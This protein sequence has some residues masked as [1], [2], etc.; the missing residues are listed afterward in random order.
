MFAE[1]CCS[2]SVTIFYR[3]RLFLFFFFKKNFDQCCEKE[4]SL[5]GF[6]MTC[7]RLTTLLCSRRLQL[8][9]SMGVLSGPSSA[10]TRV[11]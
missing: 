10:W 6:G 4:L 5:R 2:F 1:T 7:E 8:Q 9:N 11:G 3:I